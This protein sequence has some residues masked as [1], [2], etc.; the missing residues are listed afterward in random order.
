MLDQQVIPLF[1]LP[2]V[3]FPKMMLPL[4]IFEDRYKE[5][6]RYCLDRGQG[7]GILTDEALEPGSIG[8][9]ASIHKIVK[10][11]SD[12]RYDLMVLGGQR[13]RLLQPIDLLGFP[14][15]HVELID[16]LPEDAVAEEQVQNMLELYKG[17][18]SRLALKHSQR[19]DLS[20][21]LDDINSE[22]DISYIISQTI[23]MDAQRQAELL[24]VTNPVERV[25]KLTGELRRL[26]RVN[27]I[28]RNLF[29]SD[30]FDPSMN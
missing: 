11:Y 19:E 12:G 2:R 20:D 24:G 7:F 9:M 28:A 29:E 26:R 23:G 16:D 30:D 8:T 18:I 1:A 17:F 25:E 21:I 4:H 3:L 10:K 14:Q 27:Q 6:I 5:M 15:G 13:F 22:Q